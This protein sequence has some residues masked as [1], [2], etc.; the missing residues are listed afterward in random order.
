MLAEEA[1]R[2]EDAFDANDT[3]S[4][5]HEIA[6]LRRV[7]I[8]LRRA[9]APQ[10]EALNHFAIEEA[11]WLHPTARARLREAAE[12]VTRLTEELDGLRERAAIIHDQM[13]ERRAEQTNRLMLVLAVVTVVFAPLTLITGLLGMNTGGVPLT[14]TPRGFEYVIWAMLLLTGAMV[15]FF[16]W[17]KWL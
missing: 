12:H 4:I 15:G 9:V 3:G 11:P 14:D 8:R 1:D 5:G 16:R 6:D 10:R 13:L 17:R 2:L 7:A